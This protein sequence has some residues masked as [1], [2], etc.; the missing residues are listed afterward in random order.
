MAFRKKNKSEQVPEIPH[1]TEQQPNVVPQQNSVV[2]QQQFDVPQQF[3]IPQQ[4]GMQNHITS[5]WS[6]GEVPTETTPMIV[7]ESTGEA[8]DVLGALVKILN[9]LED[10][11]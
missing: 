11:S 2:P 10:E 3:D 7:N 9:I 4:P 8:L 1:A 6:I 5:N